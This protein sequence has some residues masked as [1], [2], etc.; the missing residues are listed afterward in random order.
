VKKTMYFVCALVLATAAW[1]MAVPH[2][3]PRCYPNTRFVILNDGLVRDTLTKLQWQQTASGT[4]MKGAD[5]GPY[6]SSL[7]LRL[8]TVKELRSLLDLTVSSGAKINQTAFPGTSAGCY[9]TSSPGNNG[10][11]VWYVC[12]NNGGSFTADPASNNFWARCVR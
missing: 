4:L 12:F 1:P 3:A 11:N 2:A 8:P 6:C 7:S 10:S 5:A 9:W